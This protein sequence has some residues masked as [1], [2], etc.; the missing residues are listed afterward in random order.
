MQ[1]QRDDRWILIV[2]T[3]LLVYGVAA[4]FVRAPSSVT[5]GFIGSEQLAHAQVAVDEQGRW[6]P[7]AKRG[8]P[9]GF[10]CSRPAWS[11]VTVYNGYAGQRAQTCIWVHPQPA[12]VKTRISW[13]MPAQGSTI[14]LRSSLFAGSGPGPKT[15][16]HLFVNDKKLASVSVDDPWDY[17]STVVPIGAIPIASTLSVVVQAAKSDWRKMCI[18]VLIRGNRRAR[19]A[20]LAPKKSKS[21]GQR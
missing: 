19:G 21:R 5:R 18:E 10:R 2:M 8:Y 9:T 4:L 20:K 13:A 3:G 7:C 14:E 1:I 6:R 15:T 16:T 12:G 11:Q 17:K